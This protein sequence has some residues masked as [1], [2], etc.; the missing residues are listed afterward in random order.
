[1][2]SNYFSENPR[3][4][5]AIILL[6]SITHIGSAQINP[7]DVDDFIRQ[8]AYQQKRALTDLETIINQ[9][10]FQQGIIEKMNRPAEGSMTWERYRKIFMTPERIAVGVD[11]WATN[12]AILDAVSKETGV[13]EEA[14]IGILGVETYFGQR[15]GNYRVLDALYTLAFGYPRRASFFKAELSKFLEL[16][17][18]EGLDP[19]VIKGSYA[20]AMGYGQFMPS[21]YLA[22]AKSYNGNSGADLMNQTDDAIASVAN[23]LKVHRWQQGGLVAIPASKSAHAQNLPK[24]KVKPTHAL[25]YYAQKGYEPLKSVDSAESVSLQVM[26]ME[27]GSLAY[28]FAFHNFYVITR[29]NHSPLYALAVFQLGEA[30]KAA[31]KSTQ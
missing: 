12:A 31:R 30:I 2:N 3:W 6:I 19:L 14:I 8:T 20:G 4:L 24:Q 27:N 15:M 22:Y 21:S 17:E 11:F 10:E 25:S 16:C 26:D 23:Y 1:M 7:S 28:W 18:K 9:A 13:A 5:L 29:Y